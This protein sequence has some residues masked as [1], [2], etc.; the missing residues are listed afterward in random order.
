MVLNF[1]CR[2]NTMVK[3]P[4]VFIFLLLASSAQAWITTRIPQTQKSQGYCNTLHV[5]SF[6]SFQ[7][8]KKENNKTKALVSFFF[9][10]LIRLESWYDQS[11][12]LWPMGHFRVTCW[13]A[14]LNSIKNPTTLR[15]MFQKNAVGAST[16][17]ENQWRESLNLFRKWDHDQDTSCWSVLIIWFVGPRCVTVAVTSIQTCCSRDPILWECETWRWWSRA[18]M[19]SC[20][21][22]ITLQTDS[23]IRLY[24]RLWTWL[25]FTSACGLLVVYV[26]IVYYI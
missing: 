2:V 6:L 18:E 3:R 23:F 7:G 8:T 11:P 10:Q 20:E 5:I 4:Q 26:Y 1:I 24:A 16:Q 15:A 14:F 13:T 22:W 25:M 21:H 12:D 19:R 9:F 17:E